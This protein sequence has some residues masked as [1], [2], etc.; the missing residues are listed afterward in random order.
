MISLFGTGDNAGH[1]S[2]LALGIT[3]MPMI[4][5]DNGRCRAGLELEK[6][7]LG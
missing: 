6:W 3:R 2:L 4:S 5:G 7:N 1:G